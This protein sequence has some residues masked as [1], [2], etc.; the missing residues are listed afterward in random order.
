MSATYNT[1]TR[2]APSPGKSYLEMK[3]SALPDPFQSSINPTEPAPP[4]ASEAASLIM[5]SLGLAPPV[6]TFPSC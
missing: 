1:Q 2:M 4:S 6:P 3:P 5:Q